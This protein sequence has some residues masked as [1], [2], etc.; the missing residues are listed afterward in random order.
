[1][2]IGIGTLI[3]G[4]AAAVLGYAMGKKDGYAECVEQI[5]VKLLKQSVKEEKEN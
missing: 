2:N 3:L 4:G 1:M 5:E